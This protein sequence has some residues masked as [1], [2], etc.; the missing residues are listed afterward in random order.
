MAKV[1]VN[2]PKTPVTEGSNGMAAAT[3]P[4]VCKMPGPPAPFVPTPLPN[5]GRSGL[6]PKNYSK[7]VT[8]EGKEVAIRGATFGSMGMGPAMGPETGLSPPTWKARRASWG[9]D[10]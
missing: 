10:P 4:N 3:L 1:S 8:I 2:A 9:P 6:D 7:S 5:I